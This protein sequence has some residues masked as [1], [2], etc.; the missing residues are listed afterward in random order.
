LNQMTRRIN[1]MLVSS[2]HVRFMNKYILFIPFILSIACYEPINI[3]LNVECPSLVL[4]DRQQGIC[5]GV[6]KVCMNGVLQE[7][8]YFTVE[9]YEGLNELSCDGLDNDCDGQVDEVL[10]PPLA[11]IQS[12][13]CQGSI[14]TC[15]MT[16]TEPDYRT[17]P[18]YEETEKTCDGLDNDCDGQIDE[19]QDLEPILAS[20][21]RGVCQ[22]TVTICNEGAWQDPLYDF[23]APNYEAEELSCDL[24][25]NDC[26]GEIDEQNILDFI[27]FSD[28]QT[29]PCIG[30]RKVCARGRWMEPNYADISDFQ[31]KEQSCDRVDN[32]CDGMVDEASDLQDVAMP[33]A[34]QLGLCS[35]A[36]M[37]CFEGMWTEPVYSNLSAYQSDE[38]LCD[39]ID[40]DCDGRI[41]EPRDETCDGI[42]NDCDG[43]VDEMRDLRAIAPQAVKQ[44]G[45]C[46]GLK[47]HCVDGTWSEPNYADLDTYEPAELSC[48]G[49]DNDCDGST[50]E[51]SVLDFAPLASRQA[52][53]CQ[54]LV[55]VCLGVAGWQEPDYLATALGY[56][57]EEHRCDDIDEDC[58]GQVDEHPAL[59]CNAPCHPTCPNLNFVGLNG[60]PIFVGATLNPTSDNDNEQPVRTAQVPPFQ[61]MRSELTVGEYRLCVIDEYCEL[62]LEAQNNVDANWRQ[63]NDALPMNYLSW[64][65]LQTYATWV[66]ARLPSEAEWE[67]AARSGVSNNNIP[68]GR[69]SGGCHTNRAIIG[70]QDCSFSE[71]YEVCTYPSG[72]SFQG[73]C[74]LIGNLAEWALDEYQDN[75]SNP[76]IAADPRCDLG[77]CM[78]NGAL[79]V[80]KGGDWA[81]PLRRVSSAYRR[82]QVP[83]LRRANTGGR[84]VKDT[85]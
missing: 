36:M 12:G 16:W 63:S 37:I 25:D 49:L 14:K 74:D 73:L 32:D 47:K 23:V 85:Q 81:T 29:G 53:V 13:V 44:L 33:V 76:P 58:D 21:Q 24:L 5:G 38:T 50:D 34:E 62:P 84:L 69:L 26:D 27:P 83:T 80:V 4:S 3:D 79:R 77:I 40:N 60:G 43:E 2:Y 51:P 65:D 59:P 18:T 41:D 19:V 55:K 71:S 17:V 10:T 56:T 42:D 7:P 46:T 66:G 1:K 35:T 8:D 78:E 22:G 57:E 9:N 45:V 82:A 52:G 48:D 31:S 70:G 20:E 6:L 28:R 39:G 54:G 68:W 30:S 61:M 11:D 75:H 67:W 15:Q 72:N 64:A